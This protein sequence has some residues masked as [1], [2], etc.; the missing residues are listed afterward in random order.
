M[1]WMSSYYPEVLER[2]WQGL[3]RRMGPEAMI[4]FRSAHSA[5]PFLDTT[6]VGPKRTPLRAH[7][8]FR[9]EE[10]RALSLADRVHTYASFHIAV[11]P[12]A[13]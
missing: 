6:R 10:A 13:A 12:E 8:S 9:S 11:V 5:P 4:L 3:L 2:E 1:D 7:L